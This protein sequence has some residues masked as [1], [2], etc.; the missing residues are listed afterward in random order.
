MSYLPFW[1]A[2]AALAAVMVGH[3]IVTRRMMA[4]S[5]RYTALIDR[6]RSGPPQGDD[7]AEMSD[8]ELAEALRQA[9]IETFGPG[10]LGDLPAAPAPAQTPIERPLPKQTTAAHLVFL[11]ALALG[12]LASAAL[13]GTLAP[14]FGLRGDVFAA[15]TSGSPLRTAALLFVGGALVGAGTRM[16]GGCTSGHGL[17]GVSRF[18]PGSLVATAAFFGAGALVSLLLARLV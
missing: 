1:S 6:L 2:G 18:Q 4:V 8:A 9:T 16:A 13:T 7:V 12:G 3:W 15:V 17:C 11:A 10:A 5:G 14:R